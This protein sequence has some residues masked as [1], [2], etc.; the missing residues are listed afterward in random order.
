MWQVFSIVI[1]SIISGSPLFWFNPCQ[2][3]AFLL[4]EDSRTMPL[5]TILRIHCS[6][7]LLN[8][9]NHAD[10]ISNSMKVVRGFKLSAFYHY[11]SILAANAFAAASLDPSDRPNYESFVAK[12]SSLSAYHRKLLIM[13]EA[14]DHHRVRRVCLVGLRG[15]LALTN[16]ITANPT[17]QIVVFDPLLDARFSLIHFQHIL[18]MHPSRVVNLIAGDLLRSLRDFS[19]QF[20]EMKCQML[21]LDIAGLAPPSSTP[22][23]LADVLE[24]SLS[25]VDPVFN[26]IVLNDAEK[27]DVNAA[28]QYVYQKVHTGLACPTCPHGSKDKSRSVP[29]E[30]CESGLRSNVSII[31]YYKGFQPTPCVLMYANDTDGRHMEFLFSL[32]HCMPEGSAEVSD[33]PLDEDAELLVAQL[34][35]HYSDPDGW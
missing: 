1:L 22:S 31:A 15:G 17:A 21:Y 5:D 11:K 27:P 23:Y 2:G 29:L 20:P 24:Q 28:F 10:C 9:Q 34:S 25:L 18:Q 13:Q 19:A 35:S 4:E 16:A 8:Q 14:M 7:E 33:P 32:Q 30:G 12:E 6:S 26:R 3:A